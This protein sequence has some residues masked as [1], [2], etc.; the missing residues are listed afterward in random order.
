M[1]AKALPVL[2]GRARVK[3]Q[4]A[5]HLNA[6]QLVLL[7]RQR[8]KA[9]LEVVTPDD[10]GHVVA[11][12]VGRIGIVRT[13]GHMTIRI[14]EDSIVDSAIEGDSGEL[15]SSSRCGKGTPCSTARQ[16]AYIFPGDMKEMWSVV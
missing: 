7:A 6:G 13:F 12:G 16:V 10:L 2:V 15:T 11:V 9:K 14:L 5:V 8:G 1:S 3:G 4:V